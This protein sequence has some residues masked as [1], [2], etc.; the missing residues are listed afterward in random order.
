MHLRRRFLGT[1]SIEEDGVSFVA[2]KIYIY[3]NDRS[4]KL[5]TET[6][7]ATQIVSN[8]LTL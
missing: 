1:S 7:Q 2:L 6:K 3:I 8:E 4:S 5:E